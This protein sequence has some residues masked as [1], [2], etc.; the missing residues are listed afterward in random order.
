MPLSTALCICLLSLSR[1]QFA[2]RIYD[3]TLASHLSHALFC[4]PALPQLRIRMRIHTRRSCLTRRCEWACV[5]TSCVVRA[6]VGGS[7]TFIC[8]P[9]SGKPAPEVRTRR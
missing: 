1:T 6:Q 5:C 3:Y 8:R 7:A 9:P 2:Q 4:A